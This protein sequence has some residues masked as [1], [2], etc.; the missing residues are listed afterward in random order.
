MKLTALTTVDNSFDPF[1]NFIAWYDLDH[2]L[3]HN[4]CEKIA[5]IAKTSDS[6]SDIENDEEI[7]N[8][9]NEI[10]KNDFLDLY[11]KVVKEV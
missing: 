10:I 5:E 7:E 11:K 6:L 3:G 9:I 2:K 4:C 1:D 8:A